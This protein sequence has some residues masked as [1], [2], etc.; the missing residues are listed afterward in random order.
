MNT[1]D[2]MLFPED[3]R[4]I[5]MKLRLTQE[6]AGERIGGGRRA[7]SKYESG[8]VQP[9]AAVENLLR[10]YEQH[11]EL[12]N[13]KGGHAHQQ[14]PAMAQ[15]PFEISADDLRSLTGAQ[16]A[17]LLRRL[18]HAE[19]LANGLPEDG[20]HVASNITSPDGGEDAR[21]EW[22]GGVARTSFL[23]SRLCQFQMKAGPITPSKA[24]R[25]VT[26]RGEVKPMIRSVI[27]A[28]SNY[29]MLSTHP[30]VKKEIEA[31][32]RK[33]RQALRDS[34]LA[35]ENSQ[36]GFRSGEQIAAWVNS[37]PSV[38]LWLFERVRPGSVRT[39]TTY[40]GW[41]RRPEHHAV[42]FSDDSRL[43]EL[44]ERILA[45]A[46]V[47]GSTLRV[48]GLAGIGK[49]R[50]VFE[51]FGG[52]PEK[53]L[54]MYAVDSESPPGAVKETVS[55][56]ADSQRRAVVVV[57]ECDINTHRQLEGMVLRAGSQI[58]LIT[59]DD[60][61]PRNAS[62]KSTF[63]VADSP[64]EVVESIIE[65]L[66]PGSLNEDKRRLS[67]FA[68]GFPAVAVRMA[69][70]WETGVPIAHS[71]NDDLV[72][73]F[74]S[75]RSPLNRDLLLKS[76]QLVSAF[77]LMGWE[78]PIAKQ[79]AGVAGFDGVLTDSEFRRG[80]SD[81]LSRGI[82]RQRGRC[83][84]LQPRPIAMNLAAR[85]W[86]EWNPDKW[87][88]VLTGATNS[89]LNAFAARQ[90]ALINTT[91]IA[92]DV[93]GHV[94]RLGGPLSDFE[95]LSTAG[96]P[97]V[98]SS[99]AEIDRDGI[100]ALIE[101]ITNAVGDLRLVTGDVRR[102]L[103]AAAEK[104]AF[105]PDTFHAGADLLLDFA[106]HEN[107]H[108]ANNATSTFEGLFTLYL[109]GTEAN[110]AARLEYWDHAV[111]T[112]D[113]ARLEVLVRAL[114]A[115]AE[116]GGFTRAAGAE[117]H[118]SL[119]ALES[120]KPETRQDIKD[121]TTGFVTRL[122]DLGVRD[123]EVG[124]LARRELGNH[125]RSLVS[126]GFIDLVEE[127][128]QRLSDQVVYWPEGLRG[129]ASTLKYGDDLPAG[130]RERVNNIARSLRAPD[131][132]S[133]V[134]LL[135]TQGI[136]VQSGEIDSTDFAAQ[137]EAYVSAIDELAD[138]LIANVDVFSA[139]LPD[140]V[141][142]GQYMAYEFGRSLGES[143]DD[144]LEWLGAIIEAAKETDPQAMNHDLLV[145]CLTGM[146]T[147][148]P[149]EVAVMKKVLAGSE[150]FAPAFT[151]LCS[152]L[153]EISHLDVKITL[154]A[155]DAGHLKPHH[156]RPWEYGGVLAE[157]PVD[158]VAPLFNALI[159]HSPQGMAECADLMGMYVWGAP[160]KLADIDEQIVKLA[161]RSEGWVAEYGRNMSDY[162]F[163][164]LMKM[165]LI[166]G[167]D[168]G[169]ARSTAF[170]LAKSFVKI[171]SYQS[172]RLFKPILPLLL[173]RFA[174]ISWPIIG[175]SIVD[176][177]RT[178]A[179]LMFELGGGM[180]VSDESDSAILNLPEDVLFA[181]CHAI[182]E[183]APAIAAR[184][185]PFLTTFDRN[186]AE[187][188]IHPRML[189]LIDEFGQREDVREE[190]AANIWTFG[191]SGSRTRS[192]EIFYDPL[193]GL[194]GHKFRDVRRW[195]RRVSSQLKNAFEQAKNEDEEREARSELY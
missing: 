187:R 71:T 20:I 168:D 45:C 41:G 25:E 121:Y 171:D 1:D 62:S 7:F 4:R 167:R 51:S 150:L 182:P 149:S 69:G 126:G 183:K 142:G 157:T 39:F 12:V 101:H 52:E 14:L 90:L 60:E 180:S 9:S 108:W 189:R 49:S 137:Y 191:W 33:I 132:K 38:A 154:A 129:A 10:I 80:I 68:K 23:P 173:S 59:I 184:N 76:A 178:A 172:H 24:G 106:V 152:R 144:P 57:D 87:D 50:L 109:G 58:S 42:S 18:L 115:G 15:S 3:I 64:E 61:L 67:R 186:A 125:I 128:T 105:H 166:R 113:Q 131:L 135:V 158:E 141:R 78:H 66:L 47:P 146:N 44:R 97:E 107:E 179:S 82:I 5:R 77:A 94:C 134:D 40:E 136:T 194:A 99:L 162:H 133:R 155:L 79:T 185:L 164:Q 27:E 169:L 176:D 143:S 88:E 160:E 6:Q 190:V 104:I 111:R 147:Q 70:V 165:A 89:D 139:C 92:K 73:R 193:A 32:E 103:V 53:T 17:D 181:W 116:L 156:L 102:N 93:A 123:D 8:A 122:A 112:A 192:Y 46:T 153:G 56:L 151:T 148:Y 2:E 130:V 145:G 84:T 29:I 65:E 188:K 100:V 120:W 110:A 85:Q 96:H 30:Y 21:I 83:V 95:S 98:L 117:F 54:V 174:E 114:S 170:G 26:M 195:A 127:V 86:Q 72:D 37:H 159:D 118:G 19:A 91:D 177:E 36:V 163:Q 74:V 175:Q 13:G 161:E 31:R 63:E 75:G 22:E 55:R 35:I 34:E 43:H 11:P 140:L 48:V 138:E 119:E 16:F 81:L 28:G 124:A